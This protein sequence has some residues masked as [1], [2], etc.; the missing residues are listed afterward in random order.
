[1]QVHITMSPG[2]RAFLHRSETVAT[3]MILKS[4]TLTNFRGIRDLRLDFSAKVNLLAGVNGA[5]KTAILDCAAIMLSR[6]V[7][8]IRSTS[9]TGRFFSEYDITNG[10]S[11]TRCAV[12][13]LFKDHLVSWSVAKTRRG[14]KK[15]S[16]TGLGEVKT[17]VG[18]IHT[19]LE[20]DELFEVPIAVY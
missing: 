1:M 8:R 12:E 13:T 19:R 6:L 3:A 11:E 20:E 7:G 17:V 2:E 5:G 15:Q 16:I 14:R 4:L 10:M 9:G 18:F